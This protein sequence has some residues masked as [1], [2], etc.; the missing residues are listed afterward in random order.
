MDPG[1]RREHILEAAAR[2][3]FFAGYADASL[4]AVA[5]EASVAKGLIWHYFEGRDDLMRQTAV[6]LA[7]RLRAAL[8]TDLDVGAP[9][10]A[11]IRAVFV[12]TAMFTQTHGREL[13]AL[14]QIVHNL[15]AG[16]SRRRLGMLDYEEVYVDHEA[17][18]RR[19]VVEGTIRPGEL[20]ARAVAYQGMI[21]A[22]I[23][24]LR[25]HPDLDPAASAREFAELFLHGVSA[26]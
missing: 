6:H 18:L 2:V 15:R 26:G 3:I 25:A 7:R 5:R 8:V 4:A 22:M 12:R 17:L 20:R 24:H 13:E 10:P 19:G 23:G 21:D 11:V 16:D 14:D 9:A 1:A